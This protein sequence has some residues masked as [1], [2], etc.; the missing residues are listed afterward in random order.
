MNR[1]LIQEEYNYENAVI[2]N[3]AH[4]YHKRILL[5]AGH[6]K[7][8][9]HAGKEHK[10]ETILWRIPQLA[11]VISTFSHNFYS[12]KSG[13]FSFSILTEQGLC[14]LVETFSVSLQVD[15]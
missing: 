5:K 13:C 7:R 10:L 11:I 12:F 3:R 14:F 2:S 9:P 8:D 6:S 1:R 15:L 4:N